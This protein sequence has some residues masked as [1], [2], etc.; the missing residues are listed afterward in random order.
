MPPRSRSS[1]DSNDAFKVAIRVRPLI[2]RERKSGAQM[3]WSCDTKQIFQLGSDGK[4]TG[5]GH[6]FDRVF[7]HEE[8]TQD[9]YDEIAQPIIESVMEGYNGTI[10][11]YGQTS[12]GKTYTMMGDG[13]SE[14]IIPNA[15]DNMFH[16]IDQH[17]D[18][19]YLF[20]VSFMEIYN[21]TVSDLL[22][23]KDS[24]PGPGGLQIRE[25][26]EGGTYVANLEEKLVRS[27]DEVL[28]WMKKGE[29]KR[30]VAGTNMNERSSRSH[31][32]F[33]VIIE[34]REQGAKDDAVNVSQLNL[35]DLAGSER[36]SQTGAEGQRLKES[37]AINQSLLTLSNVIRKLSECPPEGAYIAYRDSKLTRIL[38]MSLGGNSKT[39]VICAVTPAEEEQTKSTLQFATTSK[40][41]KNK[42]VVNE[43]LSEMAMLN[44]A[45]KEIANLQKKIK[46]MNSQTGFLTLE[47]DNE[48]LR[49]QLQEKEQLQQEQEKKLKNMELF[50]CRSSIDTKALTEKAKKNPRR[51][52]W[53]PRVGQPSRLSFDPSSFKPPSQDVN[54]SLCDVPEFSIPRKR[55][56][57][58]SGEPIFE[59]LDP[60]L[61]SPCGESFSLEGGSGDSLPDFDM[62]EESRSSISSTRS[63]RSSRRVA[64]M[65]TLDELPKLMFIEAGTQTEDEE[66]PATKQDDIPDSA[67]VTSEKERSLQQELQFKKD[68]CLMLECQLSSVKEKFGA[69]EEE[70][71]KIIQELEA[72]LSSHHEIVQQL[73]E[74]INESVE[75]NQGK[76]EELVTLRAKVSRL[77]LR[78]NTG[79]NSNDG[80][81]N[82]ISGLEQQLATSQKD[83]ETEVKALRS[84]I[85]MLEEQLEALRQRD[86]T[87]ILGLHDQIA[88]LEGALAAS[89]Q[90]DMSDEAFTSDEQ[91]NTAEELEKKNQ[92]IKALEEQLS[93][94]E[95]RRRAFSTSDI[96]VIELRKTLD[97]A[98]MQCELLL[99]EKTT[100]ETAIREL[101]DNSSRMNEDFQQIV[102]QKDQ[103]QDELKTK[104]EELNELEEFTRLEREM[105]EEE[106]RAQQTD[107][108]ENKPS[109]DE[110]AGLK[111]T[112]AD[113]E[114]LTMETNKKLTE[115]SAEKE[116]LVSR[117]AG[118]E[119]QLEE[120]EREKADA[121]S[122]LHLE[123][124]Q[125]QR[126]VTDLR[127]QLQ[128]SYDESAQLRLLVE[129]DSTVDLSA[130]QQ[131]T[132]KINA[133][134]ENLQELQ[135]ALQAMTAERD[136]IRQDLG[137]SVDQV[138]DSQEELYNLQQAHKDLQTRHDQLSQELQDMQAQG[139]HTGTG[140]GDTDEK[141]HRLESELQT[142]VARL[143]EAEEALQQ[144]KA[145]VAELDRLAQDSAAKEEE[146]IQLRED[147]ATSQGSVDKL[148]ERL[149]ALEQKE[150]ENSHQDETTHLR[151][152]LAAKEVQLEQMSEQLKSLEQTS[153]EDSL[154]VSALKEKL[155]NMEADQTKS[156]K[157]VE[158]FQDISVDKDDLS[159]Q[160]KD[161]QLLHEQL[162]EA[163]MAHAELQKRY[164]R[165]EHDLSCAE[166]SKLAEANKDIFQQQKITQ[167]EMARRESMAVSSKTMEDN[168]KEIDSLT[169][170]MCDI[171]AKL[172]RQTLECQQ[173]VHK[174][175]KAVAKLEDYKVQVRDLENLHSS[176]AANTNRHQNMDPDKMMKIIKQLEL[177]LDLT[178]Q[179][180]QKLERDNKKL[181]E[182][183]DT[184]DRLQFAKSQL[185]GE[186]ER[187]KMVLE[188]EREQN[189]I[190]QRRNNT[191]NVEMVEMRRQVEKFAEEARTASG[192]V[193]AKEEEI[194]A[195]QQ[196]LQAARNKLQQDSGSSQEQHR[197]IMELK[198]QLQSAKQEVEATKGQLGVAEENLCASQERLTGTEEKLD[199][200]SRDL[201]EAGQQVEKLRKDCRQLQD[202]CCELE[203][204]GNSAAAA[205]D[206]RVTDLQDRLSS[207]ETE[208]DTL[209]H[210]LRTISGQKSQLQKEMEKL[211][212][213]HSSK[214]NSICDQLTTMEEEKASL[215]QQLSQ[216]GETG[217]ALASLQ[218]KLDHAHDNLK[219]ETAK[220]SGLH[221]ELSKSKEALA[222]VEAKVSGLQADLTDKDSQVAAAEGAA[223]QLH[224]Q[225][226]QVRT[227]TATLHTQLEEARSQSEDLS[228]RLTETQAD[229]K[230]LQDKYHNSRLEVS[231]L[232]DVTDEF[233]EENSALASQVSQLESDLVQTR[234]RVIYLEDRLKEAVSQQTDGTELQSLMTR[235]TNLQ[236]EGQREK[237]NFEEQ[238]E[239]LLDQLDKKTTKV[240][241]LQKE[242]EEFQEFHSREYNRL[243][244]CCDES[245]AELE[246]AKKELKQFKEAASVHQQTTSK[247]RDQEIETLKAKI[248][249]LEEHAEKSRKDMQDQVDKKKTEVQ[250]LKK[251][252]EEFQEF[253]SREYQRLEKCCDESDAELEEAKRELKQYKQA[254]SIQQQTTSRQQDEEAKTLKGKIIALEE[255]AE[256]SRKDLQDQLDKKTV[257]VQEL[258]RELEEFQEFHSR[259]YNRL[260]KCCDESDA[261]LEEARQE[262]KQYK[263]AASAL[264]QTTSK[265]R[266][267]EVETLKAKIIALEEHAEKS[268]KDL[269]EFQEF[270]SREY[271]RLEKCCDESDAELAEA[272][273]ELKQYKEAMVQPGSSQ[274]QG[275]RT[276]F[277]ALK[278][279]AAQEKEALQ[280]EN[281]D[282]QCE[283]AT[284]KMQ[285]AGLQHD[286]QI[287]VDPYKMRCRVLN[288]D[289]L[290][291]RQD[292]R[293]RENEIRRLR[294]NMDE[295]FQVPK[296]PA[297]YSSGS[298][299]VNSTAVYI[300]EAEKSRLNAKV[301]QLTSQV[302]QLTEALDKSRGEGTDIRRQFEEAVREK[303]RLEEYMNHLRRRHTSTQNQ[304]QAGAV[305]GPVA[306]TM[307]EG[308]Q[309]SPSK[310][311]SPRLPLSPARVGTVSQ[312]SGAA[313]IAQRAQTAGENW[314]ELF[315]YGEEDDKD[316]HKDNPNCKV[317]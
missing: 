168:R 99:A 143:A 58:F 223:Q 181:Q 51:A 97:E 194:K 179:K 176:H 295:S 204:V 65:P 19:E 199:Q 227:D 69:V 238:T 197:I 187:S 16:Y 35:V 15:I 133:L 61:E 115:V 131:S 180:V 299:I 91:R 281:K 130:Q 225:L 221:I 243:E 152:E 52:T 48:E 101:Q 89:R 259:E 301:K 49:Q 137:E 200:A 110:L 262:L 12:S 241:E 80:L 260:E 156:H 286:I 5:P 218:A 24:K 201:Q 102:V 250:K 283:L 134:Q 261:E 303:K 209:L 59:E 107:M 3:Y 98:F 154:L 220:V 4:Q 96:E 288:E 274:E 269:Q 109:E 31:T 22:A 172:Q 145:R 217:E 67:N 233:K 185:Q 92:Q 219:L 310:A 279:S 8:T 114:A 232:Q 50:M 263:Q 239:N 192:L 285:V 135:S 193:S 182:L 2:A 188:S 196:D 43:V 119:K 132:D 81:Q 62:L 88:D 9:V 84:N 83:R 68:Q 228:A 248:I 149:S 265:Q 291:L 290:K 316:V 120:L 159:K 186:V 210:D 216:Q 256:K 46:E 79:S 195:L 14:G 312:A 294:Q 32:I 255:H 309:N 254:A 42:P 142:T 307:L 74:V 54:L 41:I 240:Q 136:Q 121:D 169:K 230:D 266:D 90:H 314:M 178:R 313:G 304:E 73:N 207:L 29:K 162:H 293:V 289:N 315:D 305:S 215:R 126:M 124:E 18:R 72:K 10:F 85:T 116:D 278:Q 106:R 125:H 25:H 87:E 246:E 60:V 173:A 212:E 94:L 122:Y 123:K 252:L 40:S 229:L 75:E 287:A 141:T 76:E 268:R 300:L 45:K 86:G 36:A 245:D 267:Q 183:E 202:R 161:V 271:D 138:V 103:L 55:R 275:I 44:R 165:L 47:Q 127:D 164:E 17:P 105:H 56:K 308:L 77:E 146:M 235:L 297:K 292:V 206:Q 203:E 277:A 139:Q 211:Q 231:D 317:S 296:E 226:L 282:L 222:E 147:L 63:S 129:G 38:Q 234:E 153:A 276:R 253:H 23:A 175:E 20:R 163:R 213:D 1:A 249:A 236:E 306:R 171:Q 82:T 71:A 184:C 6:F 151:E 57:H 166:D 28:D 298:G 39:A 273:R 104:E 33:R 280:K 174:R 11:A 111:K 112:A 113:A 66:G 242:L 272:K 128:K 237:K 284:F 251:E 191:S 34:S 167:L 100:L 37:G 78:L 258:Q 155:S 140:A 205:A 158:D 198:Q 13:Q 53:C 144:S 224:T 30:H 208:R 108:T 177:N 257:K 21:E 64:F 170:Q 247:Q 189:C 117:L 190:Q 150:A 302:Q 270:H 214:V 93:D 244:K 148:L 26:L 27:K 311:G 70:K 264:Q 95:K 160:P 157:H 118:L 7:D